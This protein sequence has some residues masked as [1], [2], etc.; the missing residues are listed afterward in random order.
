MAMIEAIKE[1][2]WPPGLIE[3]LGFIRSLI[4]KL[5]ITRSSI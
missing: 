1:D 4:L 3:D 2:I 5:N